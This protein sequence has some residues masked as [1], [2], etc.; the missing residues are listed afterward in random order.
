MKL[1]NK[2]DGDLSWV[3]KENYV[4]SFSDTKIM[5]ERM[6]CEHDVI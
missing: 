6:W 5:H 4:S 2:N 3:K 1:Y